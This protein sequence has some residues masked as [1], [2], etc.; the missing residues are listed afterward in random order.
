MRKCIIGIICCFLVFTG[1]GASAQDTV[2]QISTI[3]ALVAGLYDGVMSCDRLLQYGD[4][5]IGT[6][7]RLDGE[8]LILDS[9]VY[10]VKADGMVYIPDGA[11]K[12]PF[13]TVCRFRTKEILALK[14]GLNF[15]ELEEMID[16]FIPSKNL[17]YAIR[18]SGT[19]PYM[20]TRSV[21]AQKKPYPPLAEIAKSQSV[22]EMK[23][24]SGTIVGFRC[25]PY[26]QG[27]NVPGYHLH[28]ITDDRRR[29]GHILGLETGTVTCIIDQCSRFLMIL[30]AENEAFQEVDLSEDR[31]K[32]LHRIEK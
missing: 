29:G 5:G 20:K 16:T 4:L 26:V 19:F 6:F 18:I 3:D 31:S 25:P 32:D 13:A 17:F 22:F 12:T 2:M 8:M 28:F 21:P 11:T 9:I 27:V 1:I 14:K 10:Q 7:D 24:V 15:K 23:N 30:P